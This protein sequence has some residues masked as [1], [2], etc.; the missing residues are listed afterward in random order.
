MMI[1]QGHKK[2]T[3]TPS[4]AKTVPS[5]EPARTESSVPQA[6]GDGFSRAEKQELDHWKDRLRFDMGTLTTPPAGPIAKQMEQ[7]QGY[8]IDMLHKLAGDDLTESGMELRVE[9]FSGDVPQAALD[10]NMSREARWKDF[11]GHDKPWPI[12]QWMDVADGS[13]APIYRM[14][15][16]LGM[17]RTLETEDELAFVLA[18]QAERLLDHAERD[19]D[20]EDTLGPATRSFVDS[21]DM[22]SAADK[23]AIARM[24]KA[25]F[26]PRGA[27][28]ALTTLYTKTPIDYPEED[29][30][31]ALTAAAHGHEAEGMRVGLVQ[32]E[33]ENY[34]RRGEPTTSQ[35]MKPLPQDIKI[36]ARPHYQKPVEDIEAHKQN[37]HKL[38][39]EFAGDETPGWMFGNG[40]P[41]R[42][43]YL[44]QSNSGD[45]QD[46]EAALLSAADHLDGLEG[47]TSQQKVDGFLRLM[48]SL[49]HSAFPEDSFSAEALDSMQLF[50]A[51]HGTKWDA[52]HFLDSLKSG[53]KS[54][55]FGFVHSLVY[56]RN[57]QE[58]TGAALPGLGEA[59]PMAWMTRADDE[60]SPEFLPSLIRKNH[61]D[62]REGWPLGA[63]IDKGIL[64]YLPTL[65]P[66]SMVEKTGSTGLSKA[67]EY[68]N[69]LFGLSEPDE[70]FKARLRAAGDTLADA[71]ATSRES[72]A[73]LRLSQPFQEPRKLD[74]FMTA[75][76]ESETWKDFTPEFNRDLTQMLKDLTVTST[77]QPGFVS[78]DED[79]TMLS[80]GFER[81]LVENMMAAE[82]DDVKQNG[83]THLSRHLY[84]SRRVRSHSPRREWLGQAAQI[85]VKGGS[86]KIVEQIASPDLSQHS[87]L[88]SEK[89]TEGY[90]LKPED[91]PDTSTESLKA[92]NERV[93][94]GEFRPQRENY[95][96]ES[97]YDRAVRQYRQA[98]RD[99]YKALSPVAPLESRQV[100]GR[101]IL[102]GHDAETSEQV[103]DGLQVSSFVRLLD[104]AEGALE[105]YNALTSLYDREDDQDVGA[106]AGGFLM[107]GLLAV[108]DDVET[109]EQW[110]DLAT[111]S[112]DFSSGGLEAR[113]GTKRK[114][115]DNFF[116][117]LEPLEIKPL[118][119]WLGKEKTLDLLNAEQSSDLLLQCLGEECAPG[120]DPTKLAKQVAEIE[121]AYNLIEEYP[122][123]YLEFR[124]KVAEQAQL[125]P[126]NVDEVFPERVRGVTDTSE[127]YRNN[128]RSLSGLI[129]IARERSPIEQLN[130]IEYLMGRLEDMP[131]YLEDAAEAQS[132]APFR[133]S[134]QT[135]RQDLLEADSQT[136]VMIAN[137]FLAGPS[138][139]LRTE[140][141]KQA[142]ISHFLKNI[143]ED[144]REMAEKIANGVLYS[145]GEA[146]TLAVAYILGQP[147]EEPKEGQEPGKG[148]DEAAI[149][150]RL[151]DAYG[152]PGI[153]M[154]QYLAFTSEFSEY[155]DAFEDAQDSAMP[156][157]YFQVLKLV[158][159]RFG[160]DWPQDLKIDRVLGSGSVNVAIRYRNEKTG[161]REVVSLGREDVQESTRYD[162]ERFNKLIEHL[163]RTPEDKETFGYVLGLLNLIEDSV[164]LE[165]KKEQAMSVQ[166]LAYKTYKHKDS[167]WNVRSIDAYRVE[168]LG[169]FMEEAKGKTARKI[170]TQDEE[171][172]KEA[173]AVMSEA[174]FGVLRGVNYKNNWWPKALF[175]NPDFHD[176]QV[177]IDKDT[178][179]V[180]ILDFGQAVPISNADRTGGLDLLTIIGKADSPKA[181]A[182]RLNKRYFPDEPKITAE[183]LEPIMERE[184]R[185]DC[186]IHLLSTLNRSGAEVPLSS[187]HWVL[188]I[189]RQMALSEKIG[190]PIGTD[191]RNMVLNHK[192]GLPLATYNAARARAKAAANLGR[193]STDVSMKSSMPMTGAVGGWVAWSGFSA[194]EDVT[195]AKA[196]EPAKK[197]EM[198]TAWRPNFQTAKAGA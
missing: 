174:E 164:A 58:M 94:A 166:K 148:L 124:D 2:W 144:N 93:K 151:F 21:R 139:I 157:N 125:Q 82:T 31:R 137:S 30:D 29:L 140:E 196:A 188:G 73:R 146:D 142:V 161:K 35:E 191:I 40:F 32:T 34:V 112:I 24:S 106:D 6:D 156:L 57:F 136:R 70:D 42:E 16:D 1:A 160:D 83:L 22:Q 185:M 28:K 162:F 133:E 135:T 168:N 67:T 11:Y 113:V 187:V 145:H 114:L 138:G 100:L 69:E 26:N 54:L 55:H 177:M 198:Y 98:Q 36:E 172:Y 75:L 101:M 44:I 176:G 189:N 38:A 178:K 74:E 18:Q 117:R 173:M 9:I 8:V 78:S 63:D 85:L 43:H 121:K 79:V 4:T 155:K 119:E 181:A 3:P 120:V 66:T 84:P 179:T 27:L 111:R 61:K 80:H 170:Y 167:D 59:I 153:K 182:K 88:I 15:V 65:D 13:T 20:N 126:S 116:T 109:L 149:L 184:D 53:R 5:P 134:L 12:R 129:A 47:K 131:A 87:A 195:E 115:G 183:I 50:L 163:T 89:L 190:K 108:Q 39:T 194:P 62:G 97:A 186:F 25:G 60:P 33:V 150:N 107:D 68:A 123:A 180:T 95:Q 141:G 104:G 105:R 14:G 7:A 76:G 41:P 118:R 46:K 10:D 192:A 37:Y 171:L 17:L 86:E 143:E 51:K 77:Q 165:F 147:P 158:Q 193:T 122:V 154:K 52:K 72:K 48:L 45:R 92:L 81:R 103:A 49:R 102:L 128:A 91:L 132:F 56:N 159:K 127:V 64:A 110:Y 90:N 19:P 175:A 99:M 96:S 130:T 169:L 71:A 23:A 152:V 197:E